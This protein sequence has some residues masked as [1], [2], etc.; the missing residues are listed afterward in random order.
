MARGLHCEQGLLIESTRG[1]R[2]SEIGPLR[3]FCLPLLVTLL[4][5]LTRDDL[6]NMLDDVP[7]QAPVHAPVSEQGAEIE[8]PREQVEQ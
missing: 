7:G 2:H 8:R 1:G 4:R 3:A 6:Q 5:D